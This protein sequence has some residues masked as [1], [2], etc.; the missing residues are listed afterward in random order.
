MKIKTISGAERLSL[1]RSID[2]GTEEQRKTI[3]TPL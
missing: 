3:P 2:A 1:K